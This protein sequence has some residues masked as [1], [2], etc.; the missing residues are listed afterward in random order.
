MVYIEAE[1]QKGIINIKSARLFCF[2]NISTNEILV[3]LR[4]KNIFLTL[5]PDKE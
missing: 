1:V 5:K 2:F 3:V 4:Q